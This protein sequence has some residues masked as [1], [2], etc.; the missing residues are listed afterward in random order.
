MQPDLGVLFIHGIGQQ[1]KGDTLLSFGE[2]LDGWLRRWFSE[3][4][5][6]IEVVVNRMKLEGEEPAYGEW[7]LGTEPE[8]RWLMAECLW[9]DVIRTP[10]FKRLLLWSAQIAPGLLIFHHLQRIRYALTRQRSKGLLPSLLSVVPPLVST[11]IAFLLLP[12]LLLLLLA[13]LILSLAPV[14]LLQEASGWIRQTVSSVLGDSF[15]LVQSRLQE[16]ALLSRLRWHLTWLREKGCKTICVVAHSQ[17][18]ALTARCLERHPE[19]FLQTP[20][21]SFGSGASKLAFVQWFLERRNASTL[22]AWATLPALLLS[23]VIP[24]SLI[25]L[26]QE[27]RVIPG[28]P[29]WALGLRLLLGLSL[30]VSFSGLILSAV[31]FLLGIAL[32]SMDEVPDFSVRLRGIDR[33]YWAS[34]DMVPSIEMNESRIMVINL[35]SALLDHTSYWQNLDEFVGSLVLELAQWSK[36]PLPGAD[37]ANRGAAVQRAWRVRWLSLVRVFAITLSVPILLGAWLPS[38]P[39]PRLEP[40]ELSSLFGFMGEQ[41]LTNLN[42]PSIAT[43]FQVFPGLALI[44]CAYITLVQAWKWWEKEDL[45]NYFSRTPYRTL[46]AGNLCYWL[47]LGLFIE[48]VFLQALRWLALWPSGTALVSSLLILLLL[49]SNTLARAIPPSIRNLGISTLWGLSLLVLLPAH[50]ILF[51]RMHLSGAFVLSAILSIM[52]CWLLICGLFVRFRTRF[53]HWTGVSRS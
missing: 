51:S 8:R 29:P 14:P 10:D 2:S 28:E 36:M 53:F 15:V 16:A 18:A 41:N 40:T 9:A 37:E 44:F 35:N 23:M 26:V 49:A 34:A 50:C 27:F 12:L 32:K 43:V 22:L 13:S 42:A 20:I 31:A 48:L 25:M 1:A 11:Y 30:M 17:G 21:F 47:L 24:Y 5:R 6:P 33:E 46:H 38:I 19:A 39:S 52:V 4:E 3:S 45:K 7:I